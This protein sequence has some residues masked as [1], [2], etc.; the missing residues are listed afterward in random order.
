M[1]D[2]PEGDIKIDDAKISPPS[3]HEMKNSMEALIHQFKFYTQGFQVPPGSTY[4]VVEAPKVCGL[5]YC[6]FN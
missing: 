2:M 6:G 5:V 4:T 1:N 3:R